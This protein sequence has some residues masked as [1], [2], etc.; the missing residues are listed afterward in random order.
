[1]IYNSAMALLAA[2]AIASCGH[3]H[4]HAEH[5]HDESL[6]LTAYNDLFEVYAEV[7][8][9]TTGQAIKQTLDA[10]TRQGIYKFNLT[11][12]VK[13]QGREGRTGSHEH[14]E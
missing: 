9:L 12:S 10:P 6:Q 11:P 1:M 14:R 13:G 5:E 3:T 2:I 4:E 7:T 8:P